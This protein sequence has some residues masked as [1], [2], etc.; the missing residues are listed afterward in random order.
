[1]NRSSENGHSNSNAFGIDWIKNLAIAGGKALFIRHLCSFSIN[2]LGGIILARFL[3]PEILGL[4]FISYTVFVI[5]RQIVDFGAG[6]QLIRLPTIPNLA[7]LKTTYTLQQIIGL[8]GCIVI[9]SLSPSISN[10][11]KHKELLALISSS[12]IGAYFYSW[13][14]VPLAHLERNMRYRKVGF[15]EVTEVFVFNLIAVIG[16]MVNMGIEGLALGNI[17]RGFFPA[18]LSICLTG[19]W[20]SFL[21]DWQKISLLIKTCSAIIGSHL[22]VWLVMLAP[23]ILVGFLAGAKELGIAQLSYNLLNT[24][25]F[26]STIIQRVGLSALAKLQDDKESFN[27]AVQQVLELLTIIYIPLV[28]IMS[29]FSPWWIPFIYGKEWLRMDGVILIAAIP[30]AISALLVIFLSVFFSRGLASIVFK[31]NVLHAAL[32]WG[33]MAFLAPVYKAM[34]VP[35]SH[36]IA[37][38]AGYLFIWGY[39]KHCGRLN[40]RP[41]AFGFTAGILI[42]IVSWFIVKEGNFFVSAVLW[43]LVLFIL[44]FTPIFHGKQIVFKIFYILR[45]QWL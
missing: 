11:Y 9:I 3:G 6:I 20:P 18:L 44:F 38:S 2:F 1:M 4:Y 10:W 28:M 27:K 36:L 45:R 12:A 42:M 30:T 17:L 33:V 41:I 15:I 19:L 43:G 8:V 7:E 21:K 16:A 34:S 31:Q 25:M 35:V 39:R 23:P 40:Y 24:T 13:Q 5:F 26:I 37:M 29:S 22:I 14:S 32:Y